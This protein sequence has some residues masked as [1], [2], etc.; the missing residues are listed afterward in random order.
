MFSG[1]SSK[2]RRRSTLGVSGGA[3]RVPG[4]SH[5]VAGSKKRPG[6]PED[7]SPGRTEDTSPGRTEDTSPGRRIQRFSPNNFSQYAAVN[8]WV[9]YNFGSCPC[10]F[11]TTSQLLLLLLSL[12]RCSTAPA[13]SHDHLPRH[14]A[15]ESWSRGC[16]AIKVHVRMLL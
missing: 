7:T 6:P 4:G 14:S 8:L 16:C 12:S 11:C 1:Q 13:S 9:F 3:R 10:C 2:K 15:G 5:I